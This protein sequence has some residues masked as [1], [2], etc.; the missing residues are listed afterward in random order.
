MTGAG[1]EVRKGYVEHIVFR[2]NDNGYTVFQLVSEEEELTCVGLF[3]VLAE[4]ELVQVSG[5][6]KEHPLYGE[7]L[8]VEQYELL[9]PEDETAMERYLGSGAIKGIGAAMAARI[10]RRF[11]GDTFRIIEE[12]PERLAEVK[13]ISEKKAMEISAQME[14]KKDLRQA[15]MFLTQYGISVPLAVKIYQQYGNRT[16]QVVEENPYRLADDIFGIGFKIA[17]E[18][19]SRIGIHTDSDYRIRS[20]LLYVLLQ[21]TG[22]G[23]TCLPKEDLL[24]RASALLGV[25]EEQMETQ[26]MNLCM[27]RKLVMKEQNGKVMVWYGQYYYMELNV[28]KMLHDLNLECEMEEIQIVK[29]LSKVEKQASITLDEMQRKAVVEAV[30]NG[31]LVIT[32]GPGTGKTTTINAIIRYFETEDMEILLAAP[33]GRAAKRMTEATGLEAK[34]L[35]RLLEAKPPEGYQKNEEN[36][37]EGDVLI[38]D[39]CSMIDI[40]LMNALLRAIPPHMRLVLVGDIDQ[41]PSVGAGNVLRDLM[42]S[43]VCK[44]VRLTK[45]FRQAQSSRIIMNAHRIN[46]GLMPDL[47]NGKT[48]DFFFTE[49]EDP[50]EAV[51]E[52][53]NLVQTKLSRYYQTPSSQI[54]VLTPM[55][56]GVVGATNLN[57]ALQEALNPTGDGL[58]RSGYIFRVNDKVMQIRNNY[59]KEIFNGDIGIVASVDIQGRTLQVDFDG[60]LIEYDASELDELVHAYATTIHKAQ[61]SEYPIVVMPVL[62]NHYVMLQRNLIYTGI[63]RA[64]KILV[65]VGTKKAISYAVH[66]VTVNRRNTLLKER[67]QGEIQKGTDNDR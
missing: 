2:N 50:E 31:V 55:Q 14:E 22:E 49:K 7:Q 21:A 10:V 11:K 56:K 3:S 66:H 42:D 40:V 29:K 47:S 59:D 62:M 65:L 57:L 1:M 53:V 4:G 18:I 30:K 61:G 12:E 33:T 52:I 58:R 19:A 6:M 46:E 45:I 25:E 8:Q 38:V 26:L 39:E 32:G 51:A 24:H 64:K 37:L 36:P 60:H 5:Y 41:L 48:T 35:H 34:T 63:T 67:L 54:Q 27:D 17:D 13:G 16:Y 23:H 43:G 20:G 44:V 28:A 9:A 15:M